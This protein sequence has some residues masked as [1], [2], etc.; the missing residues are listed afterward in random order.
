MLIREETIAIRFKKPFDTKFKEFKDPWRIL[1]SSKVF[2]SPNSANISNKRIET[3]FKLY[4]FLTC[5]Y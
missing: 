5:R 4:I 1:E 2:K 3:Q